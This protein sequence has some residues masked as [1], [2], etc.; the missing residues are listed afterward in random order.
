M[1]IYRIFYLL[2]FLC[3]FS[4]ATCY[5]PGPGSNYKFFGWKPDGSGIVVAKIN[6][7]KYSHT[8][9]AKELW[10]TNQQGSSIKTIELE[11]AICEEQ[12][13]DRL[14]FANDGVSF[15]A[16][17]AGDIYLV[18]SDNGNETLFL[19]G[20][21]FLT[22]SSSGELILTS[23]EKNQDSITYRIIALKSG[24][25]RTVASITFENANTSKFFFVPRNAKFIGDSLLTGCTTDSL[26]CSVTIFDTL[27]NIKYLTNDQDGF[28]PPVFANKKNQLLYS[29]S[30]KLLILDLLSKSVKP[31]KSISSNVRSVDISALSD[32]I[33]YTSSDIK[34]YALNPND[35]FLYDLRTNAEKKLAS[36]IASSA[37]LSPDGKLLAY[38]TF[39]NRDANLYVISVP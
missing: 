26:Q 4:S 28:I 33:I 2:L 14:Y 11:K 23:Q 5:D 15:F 24:S 31:I 39:E 1:T 37:Q 18:N 25:P 32:F 35:L 9:V 12:F 3:L 30:N 36:E 34:G 17:I 38:L 21:K 8:A 27:F 10:I 22:A 6:Y 20:Q 7:L 13:F 29:S 19:E 16:K